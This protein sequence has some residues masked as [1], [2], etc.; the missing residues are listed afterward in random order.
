[1]TT[2]SGLYTPR[3]F[4][5]PPTSHTRRETSS[6][7]V[8]PTHTPQSSP[9]RRPRVSH[10]MEETDAVTN[11]STDPWGTT[12]APLADVAEP[13]LVP[14]LL[15]TTSNA[16]T[17]TTTKTTVPEATTPTPTLT[18]PSSSLPPQWT[19]AVD[20]DTGKFYFVHVETKETRWE[21]P[22]IDDGDTPT[23]QQQH[24]I[25]C[26]SAE[27]PNGEEARTA[28]PNAAPVD[29]ASDPI[30]PGW[31]ATVDPA[32]GRTYYY[33]AATGETRWEPP[34]ARADEPTNPVSKP[35]ST[36]ESAANVSEIPISLP[37][38]WVEQTDPSSGRPYYYHN[39][40]NL[41]QW[42]R[43]GDATLPVDKKDETTSERV[44]ESMDPPTKPSP[45]TVESASVAEEPR[46]FD[47]VHSEPA[48]TEPTPDRETAVAEQPTEE[49]KTDPAETQTAYF[50]P[51]GWVAAN[52]PS[53]GRTYYYHA[54]SGVTSWNPPEMPGT[55]PEREVAD[56]T[57]TEHPEE[58]SL[59][60]VSAYEETK[61]ESPA[62]ETLGIST[63]DT[64]SDR[65][66][67]EEFDS[68]SPDS[69][70]LRD[71]NSANDTVTDVTEGQSPELP[72]GWQELVDP[73]SGSTYY[74]NEV[75]GTTS[76]DR[77]LAQETTEVSV[78]PPEEEKHDSADIHHPRA[79]P[80]D[81]GSAN[82]G[83]MTTDPQSEP[84]SAPLEANVGGVLS[85]V[86][87]VEA[88]ANEGK[89][90]EKT[91]ALPEG[92]VELVHES[93]GKT[94]Y[95]HAEDNV[96][97]WEQPEPT[98]RQKNDEDER[99]VVP[100]ESLYPEIPSNSDLAP[101][102]TNVAALPQGWI[103]AVDPSTEATY[104]INEVKGITSWER[105]RFGDT[106]SFI[107][108]VTENDVPE[109]HS[110]SA[111]GSNKAHDE[112]DSGLEDENSL[113]DLPPGWAKLTH[114]DSGDAYYYN[115]ATYATS[116]DIPESS[117]VNGTSAPLDEPFET[118]TEAFSS[119]GGASPRSVDGSS[120]Y[121][122]EEANLGGDSKNLKSHV[123]LAGMVES[124]NSKPFEIPEDGI[125]TGW[126]ALVDE[127]SGAIYYYNKLDGTSSWERPL[128]SDI[129]LDGG[130]IE[131]QEKETDID[132]TVEANRMDNV[133]VQSLPEGWIEVMDPNSG[134]VYYFNEVDGTSS[135][136]K[137]QEPTTD[138]KHLPD[139][140]TEAIVGRAAHSIAT[141]GFG[142]KLCVHRVALGSPCV[143]IYRPYTLLPMESVVRVEERKRK[144]SIFGPL[145][146]SS[147]KSM[148]TYLQLLSKEEKGDIL[149]KV[150]SIA[151]NH[152]GKLR[153][154]DSP[155]K[156]ASP[157]EEVVE[158]LLQAGDIFECPITSNA[159][160][161]FRRLRIVF[162]SLFLTV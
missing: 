108:L 132:S 67:I 152:G 43:P 134:S 29:Q 6:P 99:I 159:P 95:F 1:M 84:P 117:T 161:T 23:H 53:S 5:L 100:E 85:S 118:T 79:S 12:G 39:A 62:T 146:T 98:R 123:S 83:A 27:A 17:F 80:E 114:P 3:R 77:P 160:G 111:E 82:D 109:P 51:T 130:L 93:S 137:P 41:T 64:I 72:N 65:H 115:E 59:D 149:W 78:S 66:G 150:I 89:L 61:S 37:S 73:S 147:E 124:E 33:H 129:G 30:E 153:G 8:T 155:E 11:P 50:L 35:P 42:E 92:W 55:V 148:A 102:E 151:Y 14:P 49:Q 106:V 110:N 26:V 112:N 40:S 113:T 70:T 56:E 128:A 119:G 25:A 136:D 90:E 57:G 120:E 54:E 22:T 68:V 135:W 87:E 34:L 58:K 127:A 156:T 52:D 121:P 2:P 140:E 7:Y 101:E 133:T 47:R 28:V 103:E 21:R 145:S 10:A 143:A 116:W 81:T 19:E 144:A 46:E 142:G 139:E 158:L 9:F 4:K 125:S 107:N 38:G 44:V 94:Y 162:I 97:S 20:V 63:D 91:A 24:H 154:N 16:A 141:F 36:T 138:P 96:T 31:T 13:P 76:W 131:V 105:P 122:R 71:G 74:Y 86:P 18:V 88:E 45:V 15:P 104:Y 60:P 48:D 157:E 75:N 32:S 69:W 126:E